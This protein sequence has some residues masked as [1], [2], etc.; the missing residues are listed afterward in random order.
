[1]DEESYPDSVTDWYQ[2]RSERVRDEALL[3]T[4]NFTDWICSVN[5]ELDNTLP[6]CW[7]HHPWL[8]MVMDAVR[9]RYV[10]AYSTNELKHSGPWYFVQQIPATVELIRSW[11]Q[12]TGKSDGHECSLPPTDPSQK[13]LA[14]HR[15]EESHA[16]YPHR[17]WIWPANSTHEDEAGMS[18]NL[19]PDTV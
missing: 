13:R 9:M 6:S 8:V 5:E 4:V 14:R 7:I 2:T 19:T 18:L 11:V 15:F 1:M 17:T 3:E 12:A 16:L 10:A